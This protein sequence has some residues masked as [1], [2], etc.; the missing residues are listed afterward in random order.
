MRQITFHLLRR[1]ARLSSLV[2]LAAL[3]CVLLMRF[4]PGYFSDAREMDGAYAHQARTELDA[5]QRTQGSARALL[6]QQISSWLHGDLGTSRHYEVPVAGLLRER[7]VP[8]LKLL[9]RGVAVGWLLAA[10][11]ALPLSGRRTARGEVAIVTGTAFL[12]AVPA[13]V[14]ATLAFLLNKGGPVFVMAVLVAARDFK[15]LYRILRAAWRQPH[16]LHARVQGFAPLAI[17]R[18]HLLPVLSRELLALA[19]MSFVVAISALV[20]VEVIFNVS[21]L[22]QLAWTAALNRDM[23]VLVAATAILAA[24]IGLAELFTDPSRATEAA[25]CA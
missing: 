3:G 1:L 22:G 13:G 7:A 21:G 18:V 20:P 4:A 6:L 12:L 17:L 2:V 14:L 9:T 19:M 16:V 5:L 15:L 10:A 11:F 8:S 25:Q 23:P 24:C